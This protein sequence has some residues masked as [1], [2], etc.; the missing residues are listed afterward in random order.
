[1]NNIIVFTDGASRG[2]PGPGGW[3]AVVAF[4]NFVQECGGGEAHTTNNR[5]ELLALIEAL[6]FI[7]KKD[8]SDT[9]IEIYLDSRY[10]MKGVQE[11]LSGWQRG[12]W[13][14]KAKK[15][16]LNRDLWERLAIVLEK[17]EKNHSIEWKHVG[18]H[19]GI[20]GNERVD[21][22]AT[23]FAD[24]KKVDLYFGP[25]EKYSVDLSVTKG[26]IEKKKKKSR[27]DKPAYSY[28]SSVNGKIETHK[29]WAECEKRV[30]G[31]SKAR[32]QKALSKA[33]EAEII[34]SF[35]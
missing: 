35:S 34:R 21:E 16:V 3:G 25:L 23:Q 4:P 2:N 8:S 5:M 24:N 27:S 1:M 7:S 29:T 19:I 28:V 31:V 15:D 17:V 30:K 18:G 9:P 14:T 33:E 32:F 26:T 12:G 13:K 6:D 22:I 20:P 11:W 10:V